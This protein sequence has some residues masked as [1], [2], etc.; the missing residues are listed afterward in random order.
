MQQRPT[1]KL[2]R[3]TKIVKLKISQTFSSRKYTR[4]TVIDMC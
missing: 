4:Q 3:N 2:K 1:R